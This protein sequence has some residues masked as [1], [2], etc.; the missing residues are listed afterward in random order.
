MNFD[1][2][3]EAIR[4]SRFAAHEAELVEWLLQ[5]VRVV[6]ASDGLEGGRHARSY[7]GGV[8][9][10]PTGTPW[11]C[12]GGLGRDGS[13]SMPSGSEADVE[14]TPEYQEWRSAWPRTGAPPMPVPLV[15]LA[16]LDLAEIAASG[17]VLG[18]PERGVL[19]FFGHDE[20]T[21]LDP[22]ERGC[23]RVIYVPDGPELVAMTPPAGLG[24]ARRFPERPVRF[25]ATWTLDTSPYAYGFDDLSDDDLRDWDALRGRLAG[26]G[27]P[28]HRLG[29]EPDDIQGPMEFDCE[30]GAR[31]VRY[32]DRDAWAGRQDEVLRGA[33]GWRLLLQLDS[34]N[35]MNWMWGDVGR[36]YFWIREQDLETA[37]FG[38]VWL[39]QQYH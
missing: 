36:L 11:P 23:G 25:V 34:D 27:G 31:G 18:L 17:A 3:V 1:E 10:L 39:C 8:P 13:L 12:W 24:V 5:S 4:R 29:G 38:D 32:E 14:Q 22:F 35:D 6:S 37:S 19:A 16:Q 30:F 9:R 33:A 20:A 28:I 26:R 7:L 2:V 15:F 21:G